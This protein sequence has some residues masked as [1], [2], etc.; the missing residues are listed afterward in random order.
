MSF[1]ALVL[2]ITLGPF[3][4]Y[5][6]L[7]LGK[8]FVY[9][10]ILMIGIGFFMHV[11]ITVALATHYLAGMPQWVRMIFG[12][13]IA[14]IPSLAILI[15]V[16]D[17]YRP[18]ALTDFNY[19]VKWAQIVVLGVAIGGLEYVDWKMPIKPAPPEIVTPFHKRL[20]AELGRDI[21]SLSM[22][23]H[24]VEVT[25]TTGKEMLLIRFADALD[26]I[27]GLPGQRVH[28]SH[29]VAARHLVKLE[30]DGPRHLA[31]L[32]DGRTL[33]VSATYTKAAQ[34]MLAT[35]ELALN[36]A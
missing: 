17:V 30:R 20:T 31:T 10:T 7:T 19:F 36:A 34:A 3:G 16:N 29:W 11:S 35:R 23:D 18:A 6:D 24:Y 8:R 21:V 14:A 15:F 25:T 9:W 28:R 2:L 5:G 27:A 26:E 22:Q 1:L 12:A 32:S 13:M 4:T 33:P